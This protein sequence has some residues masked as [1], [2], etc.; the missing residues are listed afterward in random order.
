MK[1]SVAEDF[2]SIQGEGQYI[3]YPSLF[4]RLAGCNLMCG[5][6]G[7][8]VD[9]ELHNNATWRCDTIEVWMKGK[10]QDP[11][12]YADHILKKYKDVLTPYSH[13]II[14]GGEPT[15]QQEAI[16][17]F[18]NS[19]KRKWKFFIEVETNGTIIPSKE[20]NQA[21]D[22]YNIS[23]KLANS[24]NSKGVRYVTHAIEWYAKN[25]KSSWKFVITN[26]QDMEETYLD[27]IAPYYLNS[28]DNNRKVWLMPSCSSQEE[29]NRIAP[30]VADFAIKYC[31]KFSTRL[32][33]N[34]WNETTGV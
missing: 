32:Q 7:T 4:I 24:G 13:I 10:A 1:L 21:V 3:G 6:M 17:N 22:H 27:F 2:Y 34:I 31:Y 8:Q 11:E 25:P 20:F 29:Y 5:G 28:V 33:V 18:L 15:M 26:E 19:I 12:E 30:I 14:T 16:V 9:G 23:P